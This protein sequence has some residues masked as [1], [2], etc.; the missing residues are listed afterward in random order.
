MGF[1]GGTCG[2]LD[3][4]ISLVQPQESGRLSPDGTTSSAP[5]RPRAQLLK[6]YV[7]QFLLDPQV[8]LSLT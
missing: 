2:Y 6:L 1:M 4:P 8:G 3:F 5:S 7:P